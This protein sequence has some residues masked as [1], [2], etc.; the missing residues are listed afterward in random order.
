MLYKDWRKGHDCKVVMHNANNPNGRNGRK[1]PSS[2]QGRSYHQNGD[3]S[4]NPVTK[5]KT[6][7]LQNSDVQPIKPCATVI[8]MKT[9]LNT[10]PRAGKEVPNLSV[11]AELDLCPLLAANRR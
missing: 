10:I 2:K 4:E 11:M 6:P 1:T 5:M 9:S 3:V 7:H 8:K